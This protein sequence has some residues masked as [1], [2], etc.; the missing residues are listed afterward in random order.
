MFPSQ[1][2]VFNDIWRNFL[3]RLRRGRHSKFGWR[4]L[5]RGGFNRS[6]R[7]N[8]KHLG[9]LMGWRRIRLDYLVRAMPGFL[10]SSTGEIFQIQ[11]LGQSLP[12]ILV[13]G[14]TWDSTSWRAPSLVTSFPLFPFMVAIPLKKRGGRRKVS[15]RIDK[16]TNGVKKVWSLKLTFCHCNFVC[17]CFFGRVRA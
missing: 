2:F 3:G 1:I 11:V 13:D 12:F 17:K 16:R 7:I 6:R 4:S 9:R 15:F 10:A 8:I 14:R 5:G